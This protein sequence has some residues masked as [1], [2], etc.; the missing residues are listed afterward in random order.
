MDSKR[1]PRAGAKPIPAL[2]SAKRAPAPSVE[3]LSP[4][5]TRAAQAAENQKGVDDD[6]NDSYGG[7]ARLPAHPGCL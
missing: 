3:S 6:T 7:H 4:E 5:E 2:A 1:P